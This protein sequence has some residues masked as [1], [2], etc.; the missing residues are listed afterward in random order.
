M[1]CGKYVVALTLAALAG[2]GGNDGN[3]PGAMSEHTATI[4]ERSVAGAAGS[5]LGLL[6]WQSSIEDSI[7][8]D[9]ISLRNTTNQISILTMQQAGYAEGT[10]NW[11]SI[12]NQIG[13][14]QASA[15]SLQAQISS[16]QATLA[17]IQAEI[18]AEKQE[19]ADS[20]K[21]AYGNPFAE[22]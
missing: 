8:L 15:Q 4:S 7:A 5:I 3:P 2:C 9:D 14:L 19:N 21:N 20:V 13:Q 12:E 11:A 16:L 1:N 10:A 22:N 6:T 18:T 17:T